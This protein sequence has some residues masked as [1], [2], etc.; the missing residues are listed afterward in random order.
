MKTKILWRIICIIFIFCI[1]GCGINLND[2]KTDFVKPTVNYEKE[3][4][5]EWVIKLAEEKNTDQIFIVAG[6]GQ[7]TAYVSMHQKD[8][9]NDWRCIITTPGYIGKY[10]LGKTKEGD[11]KTP[12]GEFHFT[13]AFGIADNPGCKMDY[14]KV[15]DDNWWSGDVNYKY[16]N[17]I[18]IKDYPNLAK[19]DSEHIIDY[20]Y[21][22]QYCLNISYNE[23][24]TPA[25][26]SAIFLHCLGP[27]KP[28]TGGCV[29]IPKQKMQK[30]MQNAKTDCVVIIDSLQNLSPKTWEDLGL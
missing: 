21:E 23:E 27:L 12:V 1:T 7:T 6:V 2:K 30:V 24:G 18:S 3:E 9:N 10:G 26:G 11:G 15:S 16:N 14:L 5:P 28:Y 4:T 29:A 19:D 17:M 8:E 20:N 22:Y 25:R 13:E